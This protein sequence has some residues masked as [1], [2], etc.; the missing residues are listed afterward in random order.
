MSAC[1]H[2]NY[3]P[4]ATFIQCQFP[5]TASLTNTQPHAQHLKLPPHIAQPHAQHLRLPPHIAQPHAQHLKWKPHPFLSPKFQAEGSICHHVAHLQHSQLT[6]TPLSLSTVLSWGKH[7]PPR[8]AFATSR[9]SVLAF[10]SSHPPRSSS[11]SVHVFK[12]QNRFRSPHL[13]LISFMYGQFKFTY[14]YCRLS[15]RLPLLLSI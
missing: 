5:G 15:H 2:A 9:L 1:L 14:L 3:M 13:I 8:C 6:T 10:T 12:E 4:C 11:R 7:T